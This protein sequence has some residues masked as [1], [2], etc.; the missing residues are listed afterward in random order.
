M[1]RGLAVCL[2]AGAVTACQPLLAQVA[3]SPIVVEGRR[4]P[5]ASA[6][7]LLGVSAAGFEIPWSVTAIDEATLRRLK[8]ERLEDALLAAGVA[9]PGVNQA[10][11]NTAVVGYGGWDE[12]CVKSNNCEGWGS[13]WFG[14]TGGQ[15]V[16]RRVPVL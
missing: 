4:A 9:T 14:D 6:S 2:A 12:A 5:N 1:R 16:I 3:D 8:S 11:L 15:F 7:T 10:G 13:N